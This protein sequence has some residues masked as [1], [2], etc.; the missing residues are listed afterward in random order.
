[1]DNFMH[2][3]TSATLRRTVAGGG[4][5]GREAETGLLGMC[6]E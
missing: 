2:Q 4:F 5:P 1:M 6:N 3:I